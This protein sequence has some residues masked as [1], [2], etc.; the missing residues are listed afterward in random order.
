MVNEQVYVYGHLFPGVVVKIGS[1]VR[2]ITLEEEQSIIYF[3]KTSHQIL[4]RKMT[5]EE[6]DA[7][8]S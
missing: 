5:R 3:D 4:V 8:P 6:R 1:L 2:T 7:M